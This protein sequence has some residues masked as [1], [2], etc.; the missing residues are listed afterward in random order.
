MRDK[1]SKLLV[2]WNMPTR[3]AFINDLLE[4]IENEASFC[5]CSVDGIKNPKMKSHSKFA[6]TSESIG[7]MKA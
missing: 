1:I 5:A 7:I 6:C 2:K 4:L 3:Q